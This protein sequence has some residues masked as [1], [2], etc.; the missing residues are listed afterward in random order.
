MQ[1]KKNPNVEVGR[2]SSLYFA[3]GLNLILLLTYLALEHKTY[4]SD[5]PIT[6]EI[7]QMDAIVEEEI[8]IVKLNIDVPP[9]PP[10]PPT[11]A[12]ENIEIV[13]DKVDIVET[14]FESSES[15]QTDAVQE[16]DISSVDE[17]TVEEVYE[18]V[19]VPFAVIENIPVFP[20]CEGLSQIQQK[21][22]FEEKIW[23]H[24]KE[25]FKYPE[26]AL[27]LEIQGKVFVYF[28]ID[29]NG[30]VTKIKSRGPDNIL[31][32][33]AER[34][35]GLLPKMI[36]GKQRGRAVIVPYSIP[37]TFVYSNQN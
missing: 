17:V 35:I 11:L 14:I 33:E 22:C 3:L 15:Q 25:N 28:V 32:T 18:E 6:L 21:K 19:E 30:N 26:R 12:V 29:Q 16:Y 7:V 13:D 23:N 20:G 27:E 31:E 34:I 1:V 2:N 5:D 9:P 8:P 37:I 10:P 36:P 24:V 4:L